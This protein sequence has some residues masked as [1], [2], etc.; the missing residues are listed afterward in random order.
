MTDQGLLATIQEL[1][2]KWGKLN[3]KETKCIIT[4]CAEPELKGFQKTD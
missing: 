3:K 1:G 4:S 2:N